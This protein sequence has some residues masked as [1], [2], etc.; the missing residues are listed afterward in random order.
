M[1]GRIGKI[2]DRLGAVEGEM[3]EWRYE[4]RAAAYLSRLARKLRVIDRSTLADTLDDAVDEGRL[5][6]AERDTV[7]EADLVLSGQRRDTLADSYFVVEVSVGVGLSDV[8]RAADRASILAKLGRPAVPVVAGKAVND[9]AK[10]AAE[11]MGVW[12]VLNGHSVA[13][14]QS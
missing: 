11:N 5:S 10:A 3:L 1:D 14:T 9:Q 12:Q 8:Q 13:P 7:M 2:D 4:R 6:Q